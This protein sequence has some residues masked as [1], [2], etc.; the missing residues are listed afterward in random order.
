MVCY[1]MF[2]SVNQLKLPKILPCQHTYC[3]ECIKNLI[4]CSTERNK[5]ACPQCKFG[6]ENLKDALE[7]PTSRIVLSL[8]EKE[9]LNFQ[10]YASCPSC[11]QIRN[12]EVCFECN[13]PLCLQ[14]ITKHFDSWKHE[15]SRNCIAAE[16]NL[17]I[18]KQ[19]IGK[20]S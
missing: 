6:V 10:G 5:F 19:N 18:Y 11:R 16:Q 17:E 12:L 20:P 4:H 7:L 3:V 9:S 14:C 2:D 1:D 13:L 15:I 8:L